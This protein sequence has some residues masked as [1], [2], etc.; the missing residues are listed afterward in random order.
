LSGKHVSL[1]FNCTHNHA[2]GFSHLWIGATDD[3]V[4][5]SIFSGNTFANVLDQQVTAS[6][7]STIAFD[8]PANKI[9]FI[10]IRLTCTNGF[11]FND[12]VDVYK[13]I[14]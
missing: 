12:Q 1:T 9:A 4:T 11:G 10:C 8:V 7:T 14:T 13:T 5:T 3:P 2:P 6:G